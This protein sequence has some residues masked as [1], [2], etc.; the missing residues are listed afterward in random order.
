MSKTGMSKSAWPISMVILVQ[1]MIMPSIGLRVFV[2]LF[3]SAG[4]SYIMTT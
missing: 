2:G 4:T 3:L 1:L